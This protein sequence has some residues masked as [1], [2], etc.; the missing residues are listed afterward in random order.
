MSM[1]QSAWALPC[2]KSW[3]YLLIPTTI[4]HVAF[5]TQT[6]A[7]S[8]AWLP[9]SASAPAFQTRMH[10]SSSRARPS[11]THVEAR[12]WVA[13]LLCGRPEGWCL[14]PTDRSW[15]TRAPR[16]SLWGQSMQVNTPLSSSS[17]PPTTTWSEQVNLNP[18]L[19]LNL[20]TSRSYTAIA[21]PHRQL[22]PIHPHP[23]R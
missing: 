7:W 23:P 21:I 8:L 9:A 14:T 11:C 18:L 12:V 16:L 5:S 6:M 2:L 22:P 4:T 3:A 10:V 19:G 20:T 13:A 1:K 15:S 17:L